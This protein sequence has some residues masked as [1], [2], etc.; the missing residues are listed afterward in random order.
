MLPQENP[1]ESPKSDISV[2]LSPEGRQGDEGFLRAEAIRR[3]YLNHEASV[4]SIGLLYYLGGGILAAGDGIDA[5]HVRCKIGRSDGD[6]TTDPFRV[7]R[8]GRNRRVWVRR[9]ESWVRIPVTILSGLG[10]LGGVQYHARILPLVPVP[11]R[12]GFNGNQRLH[13]L[14]GLVCQRHVPLFRGVPYDH[15]PDATHQVQDVDHRQGIRGMLV[16][17]VVMGVCRFFSNTQRTSRLAGT[18]PK[19]RPDVGGAQTLLRAKTDLIESS[20]TL[21]LAA[22]SGNS[23]LTHPGFDLKGEPPVI[24]RRRRHRL[25][26]ASEAKFAGQKSSVAGCDAALRLR[27]DRALPVLLTTVSQRS[28]KKE[29]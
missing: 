18:K 7:R 24:Q 23:C 6:W 5:F 25:S 19:R 22:C 16:F 4:R 28:W 15:R 1:F 12:R 11:L 3:K 20:A 17:F 21:R 27:E 29:K 2:P 13:S 8:R 9:L 14:S 10:L 26:S